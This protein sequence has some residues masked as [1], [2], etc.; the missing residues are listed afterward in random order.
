MTPPPRNLVQTFAIVCLPFGA[1]YFLSYFYRSVNAV[2][3]GPLTA[4][5]DLSAADLGLLTSVY[6]FGFA[7]IQ[8]PLGVLLDRYGPRWVQAHLLLVAALGALIFSLGTGLGVLMLGRT[9][10]GIGVAGGLMASFKVIT[11]WFPQSRWPRVNGLFM[12]IGG[13]GVVAATTPVQAAL[14]TVGWRPLF[15]ALSLTT[16]IVSITIIYVV[17][18]HATEWEGRRTSLVEQTKGLA[19]IFR[20]RLFWRIVPVACI[21]EGAGLAIQGLWA[22]PWFRDVAG[23]APPDVAHQLFVMSIAL[24]LGFM[25]T[26]PISEICGRFGINKLGVIGLGAIAMAIILALLAFEVSPRG[27]WVWALFGFLG[28]VPVVVFPAMSEHFGTEYTGR[29]NTALNLVLFATAFAFQYLIGGVLDLWPAME[30]GGNDPAAYR[31]ALLI[32]IGLIALSFLWFLVPH[33]R[34]STA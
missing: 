20:D 27:Y 13:L 2:I 17:P 31:R 26:G 5:F 18:I 10:I 1:G 34:R 14:E 9:L 24:T 22:G 19:L 23:L 11:L 21:A 16:V 15:Q 30:G 12:A 3:S 28:N 8:L 29:A 6:F 33:E 32:I 25:A 7:A 4:D